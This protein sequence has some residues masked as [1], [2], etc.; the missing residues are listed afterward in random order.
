M[1]ATQKK[2]Q[3]DQQRPKDHCASNRRISSPTGRDQETI[4]Q[5]AEETAVWPPEFQKKQQWVWQW[6][7]ETVVALASQG[8]SSCMSTVRKD[9][10]EAVLDEIPDQMV[11]CFCNREMMPGYELLMK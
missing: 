1:A 7:Q 9:L 5:A 4:F 11:S 8:W 6:D 2:H 10:Q 3:D